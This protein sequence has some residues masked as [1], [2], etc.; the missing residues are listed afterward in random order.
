VLGGSTRHPVHTRAAALAERAAHLLA[1]QTRGR[2]ALPLQGGRGAVAGRVPLLISGAPWR[3]GRPAPGCR[4]LPPLTHELG[5]ELAG[6]AAL[7]PDPED[8]R[9]RLLKVLL[10]AVPVK[11]GGGRR[12]VGGGEQAR[13]GARGRGVGPGLLGSLPLAAADASEA[14]RRLGQQAGVLAGRPLAASVRPAGRRGGSYSGLAGQQ[15]AHL[16]RVVSSRICFWL[17]VI[18]LSRRFSAS[19]VVLQGTGSSW[20]GGRERGGGW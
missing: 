15:A 1:G 3:P 14:G 12:A 20:G 18:W 19:C 7:P 13:R 17:S 8:A 6:E 11:M 4:Q 16:K 5:C 10:I 9:K 2:A